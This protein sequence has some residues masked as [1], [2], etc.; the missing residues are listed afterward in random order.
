[1]VLYVA[2]IRS[3]LTDR[4][5]SEP[6]SNVYHI[7]AS[8]KPNALLSA[9]NVANAY[10]NM[11]KDFAE[12]YNITVQQPSALASSPAVS[13][14]IQPGLKA[15]DINLMLPL[16]N[17][18]RAVFSDGVG[19]PNQKYFR[20]PLQEDDVTAGV[21]T[22]TF[23]DDLSTTFL[24]LLF[25]VPGFCSNRGVAFTDISAVPLTQMRQQGW[26]RRTRPGYHRGWVAD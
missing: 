14:N 9:E 25:A 23:L 21:P 7:N 18:V 5:D 22:N 13:N 6:W 17:T 3:R 20:F 8:S 11:L 12:V 19:R 1:V 10:T 16:F 15:G 4:P 24:S 26:H 2:T